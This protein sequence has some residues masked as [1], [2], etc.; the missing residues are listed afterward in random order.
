MWDTASIPPPPPTPSTQPAQKPSKQSQLLRMSACITVSPPP[1]PPYACDQGSPMQGNWGKAE[2]LARSGK[3]RDRSRPPHWPLRAFQGLRWWRGQWMMVKV[4]F[5]F[6]C[7]CKHR[8]TSAAKQDAVK[9][10]NKTQMSSISRFFSKG[11]DDWRAHYVARLYC[12]VQ[13]GSS[14]KVKW[15]D[16]KFCLTAEDPLR[17]TKWHQPVV[18]THCCWQ[19]DDEHLSLKGRSWGF[20]MF[21]SECQRERTGAG[22]GSPGGPNSI[23]LYMPR[24]PSCR[25]N[26]HLK[27]H[28]TYN[29][30]HG[31][32]CTPAWIGAWKLLE[33]CRRLS[34]LQMLQ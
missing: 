29:Q 5:W 14:V 6:I 24:T 15:Q 3:G 18:V 32:R 19:G 23:R 33:S 4:M 25:Y 10:S 28:R 11:G 9:D 30:R 31:K 12:P 7:W 8:M 27:I 20:F 22:C 13:A 1:Q 34:T 17:E 16:C 21:Q 2:A 26:A